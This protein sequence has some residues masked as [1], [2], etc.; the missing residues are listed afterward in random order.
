[1]TRVE[2]ISVG[3]SNSKMSEKFL[4]SCVDWNIEC[5]LPIHFLVLTNA[6]NKFV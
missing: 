4:E 2:C 3:I 5:R 1:M 6:G